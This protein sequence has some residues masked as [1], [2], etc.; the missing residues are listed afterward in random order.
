[1]RQTERTL[2]KGPTECSEELRSSGILSMSST[3]GR[4]W[5]IRCNVWFGDLNVLRGIQVVL[6]LEITRTQ[7]LRQVAL[8]SDSANVVLRVKESKW[9]EK[10]PTLGDRSYEHSD[11]R[12]TLDNSKHT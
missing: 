1:M 10:E 7:A 6:S 4:R 11:L 12:E 8:V 2:K 9:L 5:Q 3:S